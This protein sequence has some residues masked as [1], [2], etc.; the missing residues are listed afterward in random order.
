MLEK[1]SLTQM[2]IAIV[3]FG[4]LVI[5]LGTINRLILENV[6]LSAIIVVL[7]IVFVIVLIWFSIHQRRITLK[8]RPQTHKTIL[9]SKKLSTGTT[10]V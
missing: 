10:T 1:Y 8:P 7:T 2:K 3:I 4:I 9:K 6:A 5:V